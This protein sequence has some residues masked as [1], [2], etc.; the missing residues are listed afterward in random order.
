[1]LADMFYVSDRL[2]HHTRSM[3]TSTDS[4]G[5]GRGLQCEI[6]RT[7]FKNKGNLNKHHRVVRTLSHSTFFWFRFGFWVDHCVARKYTDSVVLHS[8][9][10]S[11]HRSAHEAVRVFLPQLSKSLRAKKRADATCEC[12][13]YVFHLGDVFPLIFVSLVENEPKRVLLETNR[14]QILR[15][16]Q[17][18][19]DNDDDLVRVR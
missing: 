7:S 1:M 5:D 19:T 3:H 12:C 2:W 16:Q 14:S 6:C 10:N 18:L 17:K 11:W 8:V 4:G 13:S 15:I 9:R